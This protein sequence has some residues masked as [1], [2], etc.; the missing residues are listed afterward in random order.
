MIRYERGLNHN[1]LIFSCEGE[2]IEQLSLDML[3]ENKIE[4]LLNF[5]LSRNNLITEVSYETSN[6]KSMVQAFENERINNEVIISLMN[7]MIQLLDSLEEH[8]LEHAG[9][10]LNPE[11]VY[12][13]KE[14]S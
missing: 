8:Y 9:L 10:V 6:Y 1:Y 4:G 12:W 7:T 13:N 2:G 14:R 5:K 11:Y 3:R